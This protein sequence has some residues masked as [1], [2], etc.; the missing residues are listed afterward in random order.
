MRLTQPIYCKI[1]SH[2]FKSSLKSS[3]QVA[4][5]HCLCDGGK[6][7]SVLCNFQVTVDR[8]FLRPCNSSEFCLSRVSSE[9][10][11]CVF[12]GQTRVCLSQERNFGNVFYL[13]EL[14]YALGAQ[15]QQAVLSDISL[16]ATRPAQPISLG[17][18]EPFHDM[19]IFNLS[20]ENNFKIPFSL[21]VG[22]NVLDGIMGK[23]SI[24]RLHRKQRDAAIN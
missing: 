2:I 5:V 24:G 23:S 19:M 1:I 16:N 7:L 21:V 14:R 13:R 9:V 22:Y 4:G 18:F 8:S 11:K 6:V 3:V 12:H 20:E 17:A 10:S 15:M